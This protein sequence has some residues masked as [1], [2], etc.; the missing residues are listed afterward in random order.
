M[1][2]LSGQDF[3]EDAGAAAIREEVVDG[4]DLLQAESGIS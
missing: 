2:G 1:R 4:R 3:P